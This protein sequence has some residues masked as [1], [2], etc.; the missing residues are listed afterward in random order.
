MITWVSTRVVKSSK[1]NCI[2][3]TKISRGHRGVS[4]NYLNVFLMSMSFFISMLWRKVHVFFIEKLVVTYWLK[5]AINIDRTENI[6]L[7]VDYCYWDLER[8]GNEFD[9]ILFCYFLLFTKYMLFK[10]PIKI[11]VPIVRVISKIQNSEF[12][13][14][15][16]R[17]M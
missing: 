10:R 15:L 1:D 14:L 8:H 11:W 13:I 5:S 6:V 4:V 2:Q 9:Q 12:F 16:A 3:F 17:S 7:I